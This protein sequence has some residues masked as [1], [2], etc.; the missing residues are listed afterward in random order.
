M[1]KFTFD[2][3]GRVA[4]VTGAGQGVGR[5]IAQALAA[6]GARVAVN[7]FVLDRAQAV[8]E[9]IQADGGRALAVQADVGD[10][11]AVQAM[12][13]KVEQGLGP[14][15]ILVNNA[16][17]AGPDAAMPRLDF[18]TTDPAEWDRYLHVNLFGVMNCARAFTGGMVARQYGRMVTIVSDA[19]RA[20]EQ[21]HEAY[22]AAK[23][24]AAGFSR[25]LARSLGRFNVT[26][27]TISLSNM[28]REGAE[29]T[30]EQA[31]LVKEMLKRYVVRRQGRP[32]D[33]AA[34]VLLLAS[35]ASSWITGQNYPVN[36]G[37]TFAL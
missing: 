4:V 13:D 21:G 34:V 1:T 15:D 24:G 37:Y 32:D 27:N 16:G 19:G 26:A 2:L 12:A 29:P 25:A 22:S 6:H 36:G 11:A 23:A 8:V 10:Y 17:N 35:D 30:P 14:A 20:G 33:V 28:G 7:D 18:W 9:E 3:T 5:G 31:A